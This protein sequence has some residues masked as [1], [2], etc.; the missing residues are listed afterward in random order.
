MDY[1]AQSIVKAPEVI[2]YQTTH[3]KPTENLYYSD[4]DCKNGAFQ[5]KIIG[6]FANI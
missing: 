2:L 6:I 5:G 1:K 3:L 4:K